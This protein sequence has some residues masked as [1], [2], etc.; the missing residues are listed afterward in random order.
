MIQCTYVSNDMAVGLAEKHRAVVRT[1]GRGSLDYE[2]HQVNGLSSVQENL[3]KQ[4]ILA[5]GTDIIMAFW[6]PGTQKQYHTH[7]SRWTQFCYRWDIDSLNPSVINQSIMEGICYGMRRLAYLMA[8]L[9]PV[10]FHEYPCR[11]PS[12]AK[13]LPAGGIDLMQP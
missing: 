4:G 6:K 9:Q 11:L 12:C 13:Y 5:V 8:P 1:F 3:Q 7:V 2:T 10:T